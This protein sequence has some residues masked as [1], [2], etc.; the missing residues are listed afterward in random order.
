MPRSSTSSPTATSHHTPSAVN[1]RSTPTTTNWP[2][3]FRVRQSDPTST[4]HL[5]RA[6]GE[7]RDHGCA[8]ESTRNSTPLKIRMNGSALNAD[9]GSFDTLLADKMNPNFPSKSQPADAMNLD[10]TKKIRKS[11]RRACKILRGKCRSFWA[12][13]ANAEGVR[14]ND[15]ESDDEDAEGD[16]L[17]NFSDEGFSSDSDSDSDAD[18]QVKTAAS[19]AARRAAMDTLVPALPLS[20]Y[21]QMLASYHSN[22]QRVTRAKVHTDTLGGGVPSTSN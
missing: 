18:A 15:E 2:S 7:C 17:S 21:G 8:P 1:S 16:A 11:R 14:F 12:G 13:R 6:F 22:S 20:E 3:P 10:V 5:S 4:M 9:A 19:R